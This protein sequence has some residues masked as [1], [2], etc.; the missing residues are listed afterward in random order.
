MAGLLNLSWRSHS[1]EA[2]FFIPMMGAGGTG[3]P[4]THTQFVKQLKVCVANVPGRSPGTYLNPADY[5]GH[6]FRRGGATLAFETTTDHALIQ[7]LGD[8]TSMAYLGYR[9]LTEAAMQQLPRL[10]AAAAS[11]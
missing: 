6:S 4:M 3:L 8:W 7:N 10:L 11:G 1:T 9:E 2:A 5:S